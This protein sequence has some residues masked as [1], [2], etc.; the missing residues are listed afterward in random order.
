MAPA[1][2]YPIN[3]GGGANIGNNFMP[4]ESTL[5]SVSVDNVAGTTEYSLSPDRSQSA[6]SNTTMYLAVGGG[7]LMLL[8]IMNR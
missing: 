2:L 3:F 7:L 1:N 5:T 8:L 4:I 6:S